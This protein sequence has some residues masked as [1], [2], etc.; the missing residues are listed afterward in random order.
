MTEFLVRR[1]AGVVPPMLVVSLLAFLFVHLLPGD[2]AKLI[3]GQEAND[4]EV[5]L[6]RTELGLDR[7][8]PVQYLSFMGHA[9]IGEFG[10]SMRSHAPVAQEIG[11]RFLPTLWLSLASMGWA[12]AF[13]LMVGIGAAT[14]R[15]RWL[16]SAGMVVAVTGLS[17]PPF[18]LGLVLMQMFAVDLGWLPATGYGDWRFFVLP[19]LT[20]GASVAAIMARF[21]RAAFIDVMNQDYVRTA[22]AKGLPR[23]LVVWKHT[24]RNAL[25]P[26]IT[27][28]GLQFGYLL[29]GSIVVEKVFSW[30]GLGRL[31]VDSVDTRD[32][33]VIQTEILLFS[34]EFILINLAVDILYAVVNPAIRYK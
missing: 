14:R 5:A 26:I 21:T 12:V 4:V 2:P 17:F 32:Y 13:G 24:L 28:L 31:L 9:V 6:I 22:H 19:S 10:R 27:M 16:D 18:A 3:A 34:L 29:G 11:Q 30:P 8:L 25:I 15:G 33:P 20:L 23:R 7:P 1:L